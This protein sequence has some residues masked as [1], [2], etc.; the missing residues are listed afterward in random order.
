VHLTALNRWLSGT[1]RPAVIVAHLGLVSDL[2]KN[3]MHI[4]V[5]RPSSVLRIVGVE[6]K[7]RKDS[8]LAELA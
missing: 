7:I 2:S 3:Q 6:T 1:K 4:P 5:S 8:I